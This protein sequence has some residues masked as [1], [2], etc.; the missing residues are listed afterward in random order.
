MPGPSGAPQ[1]AKPQISED[2]IWWA[3]TGGRDPE[4]KI[5]PANL[6]QPVLGGKGPE[7]GFSYDLAPIAITD[8]VAKGTEIYFVPNP[9]GFGLASQEIT[10]NWRNGLVMIMFRNV[11]AGVRGAIFVHSAK[12]AEWLQFGKVASLG[13]LQS[14]ANK[15]TPAMIDAVEAKGWTMTPKWNEI[16]DTLEKSGHP[17][18]TH[19]GG[20]K[21]IVVHQ[22]IEGDPVGNLARKK[23]G[24]RIAGQV[25]KIVGIH[26]L[27]DDQGMG[28]RKGDASYSWHEGIFSSG[29]LFSQD[30]IGA[31]AGNY[32]NYMGSPYAGQGYVGVD[33]SPMTA[34]GVING[35][36]TVRA[37]LLG[38]ES[39]HVFLQGGMG[40]VGHVIL[41]HIMDDGL[42]FSGVSE[43]TVDNLLAIAKKIN[44]K[45]GQVTKL[46]LDRS[47][48]EYVFGKERA[49]AEVDKAQLPSN[50]DFITVVDNLADALGHAPETVGFI[51]AAGP[52]PIDLEVAEA[53]A[54]R[55]NC[56][57]VM[58]PANNTVRPIDGSTELIEW[59]LQMHEIYLPDPSQINSSGAMSVTTQRIKLDAAGMSRYAAIV[60][61]GNV[62]DEL[63]AFGQGFVPAQVTLYNAMQRHHRDFAAGLVVGGLY[64]PPK[65]TTM[66]SDAVMLSLAAFMGVDVDAIRAKFSDGGRPDAAEASNRSLDPDQLSAGTQFIPGNFFEDTEGTV[67]SPQTVGGADALP[68]DTPVADLTNNELV[69]VMNLHIET[70]PGADDIEAEVMLAL[71]NAA[72]DGNWDAFRAN[73]SHNFE[74]DQIPGL[75]ES[76]QAYLADVKSKPADQVRSMLRLETEEAPLEVK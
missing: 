25:A 26:I 72:L 59:Y 31:D 36:K 17:H 69:R 24:M 3:I 75:V 50:K 27:G 28:I 40:N 43:I 16:D 48:A 6:D 1:G 58:G 56:R 19:L 70:L 34:E 4:R 12:A 9:A 39:H 23:R 8:G 20:G 46:F 33:P 7:S 63:K 35:L 47:G 66:P 61:G 18:L 29:H 21:G 55:T 73:L 62:R 11:E 10:N 52:Y 13:G 67:D 37:E 49:A 65:P 51:P 54:E 53:L 44:A 57:Y 74:A 2:E 15:S 30:V 41:D 22:E 42:K 76:T 71:I 60:G 32:Y 45:T 5:D 68:D 64:M 14:Y 38:N